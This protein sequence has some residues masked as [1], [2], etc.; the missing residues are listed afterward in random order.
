MELW[1]A[2]PEDPLTVCL[3]LVRNCDVY[4]CVVAHRYGSQTTEGK[5][6]T[7]IEYELATACEKACLVF[8]MSD[9]YAIVPRFV[10]RGETA[11]KLEAFK[12]DLRA[13]HLVTTFTDG[14]DL[15]QRRALPRRF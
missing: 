4:L 2:K 7:Q 6:F 13:Q 15:A 12:A 10:D 5:P 14:E 9:D 1:L 3:D 8:L 11:A